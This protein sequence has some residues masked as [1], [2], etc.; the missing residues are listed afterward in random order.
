MSNV[1]SG[2]E[3]EDSYATFKS[4]ERSYGLWASA[5]DMRTDFEDLSQ[6][7]HGYVQYVT[8]ANA[9]APSMAALL[10]C[11]TELNED[12]WDFSKEAEKFQGSRPAS[13]GVANFYQSVKYVVD[14]LSTV[15][16]QFNHGYLSPSLLGI[17]ANQEI[18]KRRNDVLLGVSTVGA[19][20]SGLVV[21]TF[22]SRQ[23]TY[24]KGIT[25]M[26]AVVTLLGLLMAI[27]SMGYDWRLLI[28]RGQEPYYD[29]MIIGSSIDV[30]MTERYAMVKYGEKKAASMAE[31]WKA[32][33]GS[34]RASFG[35]N[36]YTLRQD[37]VMASRT[38]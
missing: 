38:T 3:V 22:A 34:Y 21:F 1:G 35:Q 15:F 25:T 24:T 12:C 11:L 6:L 23:R 2:K 7:A 27:L 4:L 9:P 5:R 10:Q 30:I 29:G 19:L 13:A 16:K 36:V 32:L 37:L 17:P 28:H 14:E 20:L 26:A 8:Q 18:E 31:Q 33:E